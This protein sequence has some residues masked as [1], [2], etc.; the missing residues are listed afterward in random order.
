[1]INAGHV[2]SGESAYDGQDTAASL[3]ADGGAL[4][5][6]LGGVGG[7]RG[8]V[9]AVQV[10]DAEDIGSAALSRAIEAGAWD[11]DLAVLNLNG[12]GQGDAG[13]EGG[14]DGGV[15]HVEDGWVWMKEEVLIEW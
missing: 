12:G 7:N 9:G 11:V 8:R 2:R 3:L 1:M 13:E 10:S 15:L 14:D 5:L 4:C 6:E